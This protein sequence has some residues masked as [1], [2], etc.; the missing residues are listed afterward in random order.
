MPIG[1]MLNKKISLDEKLCS[2]SLQTVFIFTW[3]IP[4]L[5]VKG[6]IR[7][8]LDYVKSN[9]FPLLDDVSTK[10]IQKAL[11]ELEENKLIRYYGDKLKYIEY[12]G[13]FKNQKINKEREAISVIPDPDSFESYS[14]V[15]QDIR[16][17]ISLKNKVNDK[18]KDNEEGSSLPYGNVPDPSEDQSY[19][20]VDRQEKKVKGQ[21]FID[22]CLLIWQDEYK[23]HRSDEYEF[24]NKGKDRDGIG[25]LINI[26]KK[27][28]NEISGR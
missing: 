24:V 1:R 16:L 28:H 5:D 19:K 23:K 27:K 25:K 9:V 17:S 18:N 12:C 8:D 10:K 20:T 13:F 15:T 21:D 6:R 4:H 2:L 14:G 7:G 11:T 22:E 26:I 3:I